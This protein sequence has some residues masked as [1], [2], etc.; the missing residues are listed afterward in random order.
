MRSPLRVIE[1]PATELNGPAFPVVAATCPPAFDFDFS[2]DAYARCFRDLLRGDE[3]IAG[4]DLG[5][6]GTRP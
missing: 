6:T 5:D 3:I 2:G 1:G 4:K